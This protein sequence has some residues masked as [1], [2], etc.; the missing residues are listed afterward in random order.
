MGDRVFDE[1]A[2]GLTNIGGYLSDIAV[3]LEMIRKE[4]TEGLVVRQMPVSEG[5]KFTRAWDVEVRR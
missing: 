5:S 4:I 2:V 1:I 3:T